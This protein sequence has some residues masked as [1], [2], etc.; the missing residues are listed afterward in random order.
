MLPIIILFIINKLLHTFVFCV[1]QK[2]ERKSIRVCEDMRVSKWQNY[3]FLCTVNY[4]FESE[5]TLRKKKTVLAPITC[6]HLH[7]H[8]HDGLLQKTENTHT[9]L[10]W[11][12]ESRQPYLT[13]SQPKNNLLIIG[14]CYQGCV[15]VCV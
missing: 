13:Q 15:C 14:L 11:S 6:S 8:T 3:H 9:H 4:S 10:L 5:W 2:K 12:I 7:T 1:T